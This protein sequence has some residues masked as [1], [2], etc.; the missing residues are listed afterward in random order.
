MSAERSEW[1]ECITSKL[2]DIGA[3]RTLWDRHCRTVLA[4]APVWCYAEGPGGGKVMSLFLNGFHESSCG[5]GDAEN[6]FSYVRGVEPAPPEAAYDRVA[7]VYDDWIWQRIWR[8]YEAATVDS[9]CDRLFGSQHPTQILDMGCGTGFYLDRL[10]KRFSQA[11]LDGLDISSNMLTKAERRP[12]ISSGRVSLHKGRVEQSGLSSSTFDL[13]LMCRVGNH[14]RELSP[15]GAEVSRLLKNSGV[16][17]VTDISHNHSY[18]YT[19]IPDR[20]GAKVAI[21]TYKHTIENWLLVMNANKWSLL[22]FDQL[23]TS[24]L[25]NSA[26]PLPD[27]IECLENR[28]LL[29]LLVFKKW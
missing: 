16:I 18:S 11:E 7:D 8:R 25:R 17:I 6:C 9:I 2:L 12:A 20:S 15:W 23:S 29:D 28:P 27:S 13:I 19:R 1:H 26:F 3:T 14:L 10:A 22:H 4:A 21:K 5:D 24:H